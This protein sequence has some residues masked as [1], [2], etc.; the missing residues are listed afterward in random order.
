MYV[1]VWVARS[2]DEVLARM[3]SW[4][5]GLSNSLAPKFLAEALED[6]ADEMG[7]TANDVPDGWLDTSS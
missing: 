2:V 5:H 3:A 7:L 4:T 6:W 1:C